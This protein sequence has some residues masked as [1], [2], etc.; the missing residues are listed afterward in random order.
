MTTGE[1]RCC[2]KEDLRS[3]APIAVSTYFRTKPLEGKDRDRHRRRRRHR[4]RHRRRSRRA[5][6]MRTRATR[7]ET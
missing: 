5:L 7:P 3:H 2:A 4:R 1:D 6:K